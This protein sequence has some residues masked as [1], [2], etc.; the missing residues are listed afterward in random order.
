[1]IRLLKLFIAV[2]VTLALISVAM[3]YGA[4]ALTS[5]EAAQIAADAGFEGDVI[6]RESSGSFPNGFYSFIQ[7]TIVLVQPAG[8]PDRW[9][10]LILYHEIGHA[11]QFETGVFSQMGEVEREWDA[12]VRGQRMAC[13][14]GLTMADFAAMWSWVYA[15]VGNRESP[16]HGFVLY[17][18]V[19]TL[20]RTGACGA[21]DAPWQS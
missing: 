17:R 11:Q 6:V 9:M 14:H 16:G 7:D 19:N 20:L 18:A 15:Q 1:M 2:V 10:L 21:T 12:D 3:V 13:Q 8:F 5:D 4:Q